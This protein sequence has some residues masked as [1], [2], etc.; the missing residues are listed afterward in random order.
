MSD[1]A[2]KPDIAFVEVWRAENASA[3]DLLK[4]QLESAGIA[5]LIVDESVAA[6]AGLDPTLFKSPRILVASRNTGKAIG[7]IR[8][9][10]AIRAGR[11][12]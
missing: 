5:A 4:T 10:E 9:F 11:S 8:D 6:I 1:E 7:V 12:T 2:D 3:A